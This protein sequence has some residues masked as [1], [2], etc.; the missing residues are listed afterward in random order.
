LK[1]PKILISALVAVLCALPAVADNVNF[2]SFTTSTCFLPG[3]SLD[4]QGA[5][6]TTG[7]PASDGDDLSNQLFVCGG[8]LLNND[9]TN[10]LINA[11]GPSNVVMSLIDGSTFT[12][13]SFEAG[14]RTTDF[15]P[16]TPS[17]THDSLGVIVV[18]TLADGSGVV[19]YDFAFNGL[20][21]STF[22]PVGFTGLS[23]VEFIAYG[24]SA[25]PENALDNINFS[26][27]VISET[28]EPATFLLLGSGLVGIAGAMRR[29]LA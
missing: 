12:L 19:T 5:H 26:R 7:A 15:D 4:T 27:D 18:G 23:S 17:G 25:G 28:P 22:S 24:D 3:G 9:S 8:M 14:S 13:N 21:W 1:F 2:N 16:T 11:N 29:R 10:S 6:F 20:D